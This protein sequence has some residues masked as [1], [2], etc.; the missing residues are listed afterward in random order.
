M[1]G[2]C[3]SK[4]SANGKLS[5]NLAMEGT[6]ELQYIQLV[7]LFYLEYKLNNCLAQHLCNTQNLFL[8]LVFW[9]GTI[10]M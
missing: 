8:T 4:Q 9:A 3:K 5:V 10:C 1:R 7:A 6:L 2:G